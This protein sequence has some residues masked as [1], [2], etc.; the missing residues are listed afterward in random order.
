[1]D[2]YVEVAYQEKEKPFGE[3]PLQLASYL[4]EKYRLKEGMSLLDNGCG[5][6]EFL[7]A[8]RSIGMNVK[9]TD[10]SDYCKEAVIVDLNNDTLPFP[11]NSFDVVFTKSVIEHISNVEHYIGEMKR[12][13]KVGGV[14]ILLVPDWETQYIIFYQDPTHIHPYTVKSVERLLKMGGFDDVKADKFVQLPV[15]WRSGFMR[16]VSNIIRLA[17]PVKK[18]YKNKFMRFS[19]ELM[20]LASGVKK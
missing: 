10:V 17:G 2:K 7:H 8:F 1:M 6:G 9:G 5:R 14:L 18:I 12:V 11:D 19:R 4:A 15:V 16:F 20:V 13:L 3:Y